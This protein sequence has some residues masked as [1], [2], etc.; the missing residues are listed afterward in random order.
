MANGALGSD[1]VKGGGEILGG[2]SNFNIDAE[3]VRNDS[4]GIHAALL[5]ILSCIN[6]I[7]VG[8]LVFMLL[9]RIRTIVGQNWRWNCKKI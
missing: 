7:P 5:L 1:G 8:S 6:F 4:V 3:G 9:P 2:N